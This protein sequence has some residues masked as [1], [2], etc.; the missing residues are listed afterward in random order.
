MSIGNFFCDLLGW[1]HY[2]NFCSAKPTDAA[3]LTTCTRPTGSSD[4]SRISL[5]KSENRPME[6]T[7]S[8]LRRAAHLLLRLGDLPVSLRRVAAARNF[9]QNCCLSFLGKISSVFGCIG[10]DLKVLVNVGAREGHREREGMGETGP[11]IYTKGAGE[12]T[13]AEKDRGWS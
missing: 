12:K 6:A 5:P 8:M 4:P 9:A 2:R 11:F 7:S 3:Q 1:K 13:R 10:T